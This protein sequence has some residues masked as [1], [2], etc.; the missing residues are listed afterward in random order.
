MLVSRIGIEP[1]PDPVPS[2]TSG[3]AMRCSAA[4]SR[5]RASKSRKAGA[6]ADQAARDKYLRAAGRSLI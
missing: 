6:P 2:A 3:I 1:I 4:R 5:P